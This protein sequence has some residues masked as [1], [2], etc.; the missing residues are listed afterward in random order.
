MNRKATR[1]LQKRGTPPVASSRRLYF[2]AMTQKITAFAA[3]IEVGGPP[4][5]KARPAKR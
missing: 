4:P 2:S 3:P 1:A 5:E